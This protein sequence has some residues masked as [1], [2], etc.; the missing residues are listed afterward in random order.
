MDILP[1]LKQYLIKKKWQWKTRNDGN[2]AIKKCPFCSGGTNEYKFWIHAKKTVYRCWHCDA[3]GN[4]YKLKR[5]LGDLNGK[6]ISASQLSGIPCTKTSNVTVDTSL[7]DK[8][9][10]QLIHNKVAMQYL[11][12]S[13]GLTKDTISFFKLGLQKKFKKLWI[14]IPHIINGV[15]YNVKF[16]SLPPGKEFRRIKGAASVIFNAD[17]LGETTEIFI[18]EAEIDA[19]SI[20]Q[21]GVTNVVSLT[22]GADTFLPE[23]YDQLA[24]KERITLVLDADLVGQQG[25]RSI[26]RRLGFDKCFNVLLPMHDANDVLVGVGPQELNASLNKSTKFEVSGVVSITEALKQCKDKD[27]TTAQGIMTPWHS[28]NN[29]IGSG[30]QPGD[31]VILSARVKVGKTTWAMNVAQHNSAQDIPTLVY[32]MEMNTEQLA[33]KVTA[34]VRKKEIDALSSIDFTMTGY[35]LRKQPLYFADPDWGGNFKI[36]IIISRVREIVKRYGVA[37]FVFDNLHFL[38]R[39]LQYITTEIGQ[40]TRAFKLLSEELKMVTLLIAQPRKIQGDRIIRH[41]DIKDSAAP[42]ADADQIILLHRNTTAAGLADTGISGTSDLEVLEPKTLVRVDAA[43][44]RG[45]GECLLYYNGAGSIFYDWEDRPV[46]E[47]V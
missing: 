12:E 3:R 13:R 34:I 16:R 47:I 26:A 41:D 35:F 33:R 4:L 10:K 25:A 37:L 36:D 45:G 40:V 18:A 9:S 19:M 22:C 20:W 42:A 21:A 46:N 5:E 27:S 17:A 38:C 7:V 11:I 44:F 43:R 32:C 39:S 8:W 24:D 15:C 28:V 1:E 23:W 29:L 30:W 6:V 14:T 31:L 2:L